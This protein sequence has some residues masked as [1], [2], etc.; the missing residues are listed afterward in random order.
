MME[1]DLRRSE[2]KKEMRKLKRRSDG[3]GDDVGSDIVVINHFYW[4]NIATCHT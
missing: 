2:R 1:H 4:H 3:D